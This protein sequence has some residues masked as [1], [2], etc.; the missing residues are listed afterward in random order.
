MLIYDCSCTLASTNPRRMFEHSM[1]NKSHT[2]HQFNL[3]CLSELSICL[4]PFDL[5]DANT[6]NSFDGI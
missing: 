2:Q 4:L 1:H 3:K 6:M 5:S